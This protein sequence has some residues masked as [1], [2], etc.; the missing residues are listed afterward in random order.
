[1]FIVRPTISEDDIKKINRIL[2]LLKE[3]GK[4]QLKQIAILRTIPT[5]ESYTRKG[6]ET[7]I[8]LKRMF[9]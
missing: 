6:I 1:M 9:F 8:K 5:Q 4:N 7:K 3:N 2:D